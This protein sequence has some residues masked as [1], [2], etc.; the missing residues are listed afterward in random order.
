M[1][2]HKTRVERLQTRS[3]MYGVGR[4]EGN[5]EDVITYGILGHPN[6]PEREFMLLNFHAEEN[7]PIGKEII[8]EVLPARDSKYIQ[9]FQQVGLQP[10]ERGRQCRRSGALQS[11]G[12]GIPDLA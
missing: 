2:M 3:K 1:L 5:S 9:N 12:V 8:D 7:L 11:T 6:D 10:L 4:D